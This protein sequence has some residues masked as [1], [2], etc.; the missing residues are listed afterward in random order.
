MV[1]KTKKFKLETNTFIKL[2][3]FSVIRDLWWVWF[4]PLAI[5]LLPIFNWNFVWWT[6]PVAI[7][8]VAVYLLFWGAQFVGVTQM[9]QFKPFFQ[10]IIYEFDTQKIVLKMGKDQPM[11]L[12]WEA[13]KK[14][15]KKKKHYM[16]TLSRAQFFYLP[17]EVFRNENEARIFEKILQRKNLL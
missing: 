7:V 2:G 5:L 12:K 3:I 15:E 11:A 17:F 14:A 4:I 13:I 10:K 6:V 16:L 9:E 8:L 1:V